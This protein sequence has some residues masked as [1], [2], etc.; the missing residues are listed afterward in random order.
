MEDPVGQRE[1]LI[2]SFWLLFFSCFFFLI[3]INSET[4]QHSRPECAERAREEGQRRAQGIEMSARRER[5]GN[6]QR[7]R[8]K[9]VKI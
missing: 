9:D 6:T 3:R 4:Y 8:P 1:R 5:E 7:W 2:S